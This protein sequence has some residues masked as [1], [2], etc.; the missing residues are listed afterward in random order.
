MKLYS[1]LTNKY[2]LSVFILLFCLG[3]D[4]VLHK[5]MSRVI[6]PES[7]TAERSARYYNTCDQQLIVKN[8]KWTKAVNTVE[9]LQQLDSASAGFEIDVYF[10]TGR[11]YFKVYHDTGVISE[12][13]LDTILQ[14]YKSRNMTSSVWL[15][16]KN[17]SAGNLSQSIAKAA[18][19]RR[20]YALANKMIIESSQPE[21]LQSFCDSGFFTSYYLPFFN[22]YQMDEKA[23]VEQIDLIAKQLQKTKVSALS[24]YYFQYP[25]MKKYFPNYPVLTW[26]DNSSISLVANSF[27]YSL[28]NDSQVKVVLFPD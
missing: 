2:T 7:F 6:L 3:V 1:F 27:N 8:K 28:L 9:K 24:G 17:L 10:D 19:L 21:L 23:L 14:Q 22:P 11:D 16:F 13:N 4:I 5:G 26:T 25:L 15:D 18:A 12:L 20:N